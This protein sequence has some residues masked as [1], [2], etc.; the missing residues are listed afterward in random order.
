MITSVRNQMVGDI[1]LK[2][3]QELS[4][5]VPSKVRASKIATFEISNILKRLARCDQIAIDAT[6]I[7][8][9]DLFEI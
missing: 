6:Q 4:L 9:R 7:V 1:E 8:L 3:W 2:N 5:P